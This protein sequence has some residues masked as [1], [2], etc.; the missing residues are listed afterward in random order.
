MKP[1]MDMAGV[2]EGDYSFKSNAKGEGH[3]TGAISS[4]ELEKWQLV[5]IALHPDGN[6]KN[7]KKIEIAL[8]GDLK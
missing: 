4:S 8:K 5:E 7:M 6:P 1:K 3:Y 2:G